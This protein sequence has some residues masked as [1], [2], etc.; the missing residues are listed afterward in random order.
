MS[1]KLIRR[2]EHYLL[3]SRVYFITWDL[4][5]SISP[6]FCIWKCNM[7]TNFAQLQ[8]VINLNWVSLAIWWDFVVKKSSI[9]LLSNIFIICWRIRGESNI[10]LGWNK[11]RPDHRHFLNCLKVSKS[12]YYTTC[13]YHPPRYFHIYYRR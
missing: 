8:E 4:L 5:Q 6:K 1:L 10:F 7:T 11:P 13:T 12:V 2:K 3:E 9:I